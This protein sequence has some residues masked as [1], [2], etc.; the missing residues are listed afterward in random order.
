MLSK[1]MKRKNCS[2]EEPIVDKEK[3]RKKLDEIVLSLSAA[4]EQTLPSTEISK[5]LPITPSVTV[6]P[7]SGPS[8]ANSPMPAHSSSQKPFS[9]T[10]TTI[11][12]Q[13]KNNSH[14]SH[15]SHN[16]NNNNNN[17]HPSS[18][19]SATPSVSSM[20]KNLANYFSQNDQ[21]NLL[22]KKQHQLMQQGAHPHFG[23][24]SQKKYEAMLADISK[25]TGADF[26][27]LN[28]YSHETKVH[29]W[30]AEQNDA[31]NATDYI[32]NQKRKSRIGATPS[33]AANL[34]DFPKFT[35]IFSKKKL[36]LQVFYMLISR[37]PHVLI[38]KF[39]SYLK[40]DQMNFKII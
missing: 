25:V 3:K 35:G 7:T 17:H 15:G 11:P 5:K 14:G 37:K 2:V 16:N 24:S 27:K 34:M 19:P 6:T 26:P 4:K 21:H 32:F 29:K 20:N 40:D 9:V 38:S 33:P 39:L 28:S 36:Q 12:N 1:L 8:S 31:L 22:L 10:V 13:N 18:S 30:L 23:S